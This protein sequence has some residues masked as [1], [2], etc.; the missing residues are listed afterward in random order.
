MYRKG[1]SADIIAVR[2]GITVA[3]IELLIEIEER[4]LGSGSGG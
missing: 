2:L 1:F 3:E 4:R